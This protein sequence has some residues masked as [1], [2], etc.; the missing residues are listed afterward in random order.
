MSRRSIALPLSLI[1]SCAA[2]MILLLFGALPD[3]ILIAQ[4]VATCPDPAYPNL[5]Y[6]DCKKTQQAEGSPAATRTNAPSLAQTSDPQATVTSTT[7]GTVTTTAQT[8]TPTRVATVTPTLT[9]APVQNGPTLTPTSVVPPGLEVMVCFPGATVTLVGTAPPDT[10]LLA[11]FDGRPVGGGFSRPDGVFSIDLQIGRERP[12]SYL[13]EVRK[14]ASR[15]L[16][17]QLACEVPGA[18]PTPTLLVEPATPTVPPSAR[19]RQGGGDGV[20]G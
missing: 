13:V 2:V 18:T 9:R 7:T 10:P 1:V 4:G 14:R 17:Q 15:E 6:D 16:V 8:L 20:T 11:F 12:G 3:P 19:V 5:G